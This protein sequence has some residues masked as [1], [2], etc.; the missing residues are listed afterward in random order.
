M[1]KKGDMYGYETMSKLATEKT[2]A[3]KALH[4]QQEQAKATKLE[5]LSNTA[6]EFQTSPTP[7]LGEQLVK[8]AV[9]AGENPVN[10]PQQGTP[11]FASWAKDKQTA[12]MSSADKVKFL[13]AEADRQR[14][15]KE[16][17]DEHRDHE[18]D[19]AASR[20]L[21]AS[22]QAATQEMRRES[23]DFRRQ[24]AAD[25]AADKKDKRSAAQV[26]AD[27]KVE[28]DLNRTLE[29][30][31]K[32]LTTD[33]SLVNTALNLLRTDTDASNQQLRQMLPSMVG[34]VKG[35]STNLFY[36]DNKAFGSVMGRLESHLS[37]FAAGKPSESVRKELYE[38][39]TAMKEGVIEP[40]LTNLEKA[41]KERAK[42]YDVDPEN[43]SLDQEFERRSAPKAPPTGGSREASGKLGDKPLPPAIKIGDK[44]GGGTV[45]ATATG[46]KGEKMFKVNGDWRS[47]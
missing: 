43:V 31:A 44:L 11:Q 36:K 45:E 5:A 42:K 27:Y 32:P 38:T 18:E 7:A 14:A 25:R 41:G 13:T 6:L 15:F 8:A 37:S 33:L 1:L 19:L 47:E 17:Q 39:L 9:D 2:E 40:S 46:P 3:L 35:R 23:L 24:E 29:R 20:A 28:K 26:T 34:E 22:N 30:E 21:T 4:V 12:A 16:K 10:I